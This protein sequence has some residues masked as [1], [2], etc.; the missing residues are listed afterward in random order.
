[1]NRF[2]RDGGRLLAGLLALGV[3]RGTVRY[4]AQD[5]Q[6]PDPAIA[7]H[8]LDQ[9]GRDHPGRP[10]VGAV[11]DTIGR[12][13]HVHARNPTNFYGDNWSSCP[14]PVLRSSEG[15]DVT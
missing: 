15:A 9:R 11:N 2:L 12:T 10:N 1:M 13:R 5:G 3:A 14:A 4:V 7:V 6:T 8:E